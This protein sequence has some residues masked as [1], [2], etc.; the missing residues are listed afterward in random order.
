MADN[1]DASGF[2]TFQW[3]DGHS[4]VDT[5]LPGTMRWLDSIQSAMQAIMDGMVPQIIKWMQENGPWDDVTG[6]AREQLSAQVEARPDGIVLV[7]FHGADYGIF[8]ELNNQ[9]RNAILGRTVDVWGV[10]FW[11]EVMKVMS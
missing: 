11:V 1:P 10:R 6:N 7:V 5:W 3:V 8:L 2:A 4:P 9:G